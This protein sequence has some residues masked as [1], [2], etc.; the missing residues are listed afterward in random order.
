MCMK[1]SV[2]QMADLIEGSVEGDGKAIVSSLSKIEEGKEGTLSFLA[3]PQY[4]YSFTIQKQ[5]LLLS[6]MIL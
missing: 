1:F 2:Q 4:T 3:N 6:T 5:L